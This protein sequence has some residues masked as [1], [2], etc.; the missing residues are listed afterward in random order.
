M[1]H[2][3]SPHLLS[4]LTSFRSVCVLC[5]VIGRC[6][7]ELG[8]FTA[9]TNFAVLRPFSIETRSVEMRSNEVI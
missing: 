2:L 1:I 7:G 8:R 5:V 3:T 4:Q 6:H 9:Q